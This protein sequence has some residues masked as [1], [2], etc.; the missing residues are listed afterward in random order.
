VGCEGIQF[1]I[2]TKQ[3]CALSISSGFQ[4]DGESFI[5]LNGTDYRVFAMDRWGSG[6]V[7]AWCDSTTTNELLNAFNVAG[8]LGQVDQPK[9]ASFGDNYLCN[10]GVLPESP[11]AWVTY[12]GEDLPA[13]YANDPAAL[14]AD[15]DVLLVCG[16][17][18]P[19]ANDWSAEIGAFVSQYGKGLLAL[20]DYE[21]VLMAQDFTNLS[22]ITSPAG[23]I[24]EPLNLPWSPTSTSVVIECVPDLVPVPK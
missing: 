23:I 13:N 18:I 19:W 9:V 11:P 6:H 5:Q 4:M 16:F 3:A 1:T 8:Y 10:P 21:G 15:W 17:R 14:A 12:L 7:I 20:G 22:A 24:F 2:D